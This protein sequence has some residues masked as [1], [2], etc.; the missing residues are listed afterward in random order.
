MMTDLQTTAQWRTKGTGNITKYGYLRRGEGGKRKFEH[1][2][3]AE[4]ALGREMPPG[5]VVHH[6][7]GDPTN[8]RFGNLV[9]CPN[10]SYHRLLHTRMDAFDACGNPDW[11][12]CWICGVYSPLTELKVYNRIIEHRECKNIY[13]RRMAALR[14]EKR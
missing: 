5:A 14:K 3:I 8:N 2:R 10:Q 13:Q 1:V 9:I 4:K 7:D 12:K 6:G 11:R